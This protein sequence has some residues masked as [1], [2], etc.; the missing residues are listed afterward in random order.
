[1]SRIIRTFAYRK[2]GDNP[3]T[4]NNI[5]FHVEQIK[6]A[7]RW[8]KREKKMKQYVIYGVTPWGKRYDFAIVNGEVAAGLK[9]AEEIENDR[10]EEFYDVIDY[11]PVGI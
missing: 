8:P 3:L 1:M 11:E 7:A 5:T 2:R 10:E 6:T 9:M 4:D